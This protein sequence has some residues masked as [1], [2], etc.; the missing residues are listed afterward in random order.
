VEVAGSKGF[1]AKSNRALFCKAKCLK[2]PA[3][4][5][6]K[7]NPAWSTKGSQKSL[8]LNL[9]KKAIYTIKYG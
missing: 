9:V 6:Q 1:L 3:K 8:Q 7:G 5:Q 4:T 2:I